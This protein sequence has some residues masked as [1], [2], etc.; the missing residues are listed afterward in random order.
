[1]DSRVSR[2]F[3]RRVDFWELIFTNDAASPKSSSHV[4]FS[5]KWRPRMADWMKDPASG[6]GSEVIRAP[7]SAARAGDVTFRH[8]LSWKPLFYAL[9]RPA[10]RAL[11]PTRGDALLGLTGRSLVAAWPPR[12]RELLDQLE[13]ARTA[14]GADWD[15]DRTLKDLEGNVLRFL[16]R[17]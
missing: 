7:W 12:R 9:L 3:V 16:A 1:R 13:R 5:F 11:G 17:D 2:G 8:F 6:R 14:L 4:D 10:C 15:N